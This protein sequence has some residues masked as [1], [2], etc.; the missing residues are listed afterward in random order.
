MHKGAGHRQPLFVTQRQVD[1][2][3]IGHWPK[4]ELCERPVNLLTLPVSP[5]PIGAA[6]KAEVL[7]YT[8]IAIQ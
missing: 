3:G 4:L 2:I 5:Q 1:A 7:R 6:E 8:Q